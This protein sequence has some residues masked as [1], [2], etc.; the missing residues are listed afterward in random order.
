MPIKFQIPEFHIGPLHYTPKANIDM[1]RKDQGSMTL[2]QMFGSTDDGIQGYLSPNLAYWLFQISDSIYDAV[3]RISRAW[4]EMPI[5]VRDIK[6]GEF[7]EHPAIELFQKTDMRFTEG[8]LKYEMMASYLLTGEAFPVLLGNTG[9]EPVGLFHY[10]AHN[11][12]IAQGTDGYIQT[13]IATYQSVSKVFNRAENRNF[14]TYVF[15]TTDKL[16][17]MMQ[18]INMR[19]RN[20]LRAQSPLEGIY[21]QALTKY[22]GNIHNH[23]LVKNGARPS[24]S[25]SPKE[26]ITSQENW[27]AFRDEWKSGFES[28]SGRGRAIVSPRPVEY[29]NFILNT[30]D[31]DFAKLLDSGKNDIYTVFNIPLAMVITDAMTMDNYS[32]SINMFYDQAVMPPTRFLLKNTGDFILSR[33][34]DGK[35]LEFAI[36]EKALPALKDRLYARA[37]AM[38]D[39]SIYS[40]DEIRTETGYEGCEDKA[41]GDI[42]LVPTTLQPLEEP[43]EEPEYNDQGQE[44]DENGEPLPN[45]EDAAGDGMNPNERGKKPDATEALASGTTGRNTGNDNGGKLGK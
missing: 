22:Y 17:Q 6:S 12:N 8:Q 13:C 20:Y 41:L 4:M 35:G 25:I 2:N 28:L 38:R 16:C 1:E 29:L 5:K 9:Y 21:Y 7:V 11:I 36:D 15:E 30:R 32:K 31:M 43:A 24:G 14:S 45:A 42:I 23:S 27:E 34:K 10:P 19:R 33:Y 40:Q 37:K 26:P 3:N 44:L 39:A 18:V